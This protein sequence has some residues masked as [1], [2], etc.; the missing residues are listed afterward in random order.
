MIDIISNNYADFG[1]TLAWE[2]LVENHGIRYSDET[3]RRLMIGAELWKSRKRKIIS[4]HQLRERRDCLGELVQ[5]DGSPHDWFEGRSPKCTLL[6]F[7]ADATGKLL[8][9][10]FAESESTAAYFRSVRRYLEKHGR[11]LKDV[12]A[13]VNGWNYP[14][15]LSFGCSDDC[16]NIVAGF[17]VSK[18]LHPYRDFFFNHQILMPYISFFVQTISDP[19]NIYE[20][21]LR[22]RQT[23][24]LF[25][26]IFNAFL[27]L[28]F[29]LSGFLFV[30][31]WLLFRKFFS[32][33]FF[34]FRFYFC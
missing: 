33:F 1:P 21:I 20:L 31:F 17:F 27:I 16:L 34:F 3:V 24:L 14:R 32:W 25:S 28:R 2:K 26:F 11:S 18:G 10:E 19:I 6:V 4:L 30:L 29:R 9:L 13:F 5:A 23:L 7:I 22:H 12:H 15:A 8:H